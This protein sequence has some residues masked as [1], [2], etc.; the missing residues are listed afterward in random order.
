VVGGIQPGKLRA[1]VAEALVDG[2][3]AD[4][5]LQRIQ[6]LVWR[7]TAPAWKRPAKWPNAEAKRRAFGL[8]AALDSLDPLDLG[9]EKDPLA[10]DKAPPFLRFAADAQDLFDLWR[11]E[12]EAR[13]RTP[14]MSRTPAFLS[15]IAK[16]RSLMPSLAL[17][18]DLVERVAGSR[19]MAGGVAL[20]S[21]Q[22]AAALCDFLEGHARKVYSHELAPGDA[23]ARRLA[24]RIQDGQVH[25]GDT[26]RAIYRPQWSGLSTAETVWAGLTRLQELGWVKI[27]ERPTQGRAV[28]V[29][30]VH[31]DL[32]GK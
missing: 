22:R 2:A 8:Y 16:Y 17:L 9:A 32:R 20:A 4:G 27:E 13:L 15:H 30:R 11:G 6:L 10:G 21:A 19:P 23:A 14:E 3:G 12:L 1:Y 29:V 18:T 7:D 24:E 28:E 5:L 31:P 25:D 26:A